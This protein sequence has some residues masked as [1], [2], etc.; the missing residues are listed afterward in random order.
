MIRENLNKNKHYYSNSFK[1][2]DSKA[3]C[4]LDKHIYIDKFDDGFEIDLDE[5]TGK[6]AEGKTTRFRLNSYEISY[7][8]IA[9]DEHGNS[10]RL[11]QFSIKHG[12]LTKI[13]EGIYNQP[14]VNDRVDIAMPI[15][16]DFIIEAKQHL[17]IAQLPTDFLDLNRYRQAKNKSQDSPKL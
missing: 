13:C 7:S 2:Y 12:E 16:Y 6:G 4:I 15:V 17:I 3:D 10:K 5:R 8:E 9:H 14:I 11:D 1:A